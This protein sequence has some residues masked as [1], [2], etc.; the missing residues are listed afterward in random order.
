MALDE[1]FLR[2]ASPRADDIIVQRAARARTIVDHDLLAETFRQ[3]L[4]N[5]PH[6]HV[7]CAARD[8]RND[9]FY[10][11]DRVI[12]GAYGIAGA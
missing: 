4:R 9:D 2:A 10:G 6:Q 5:E 8:L 1:M 7:G 3:S 12:V 11:L